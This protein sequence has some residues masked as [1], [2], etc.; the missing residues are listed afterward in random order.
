MKKDIIRL[1]N[2]FRRENINNLVIA[3]LVIL[4]LISI[5]NVLIPS[6]VSNDR[7]ISRE[8]NITLADG[9]RI[10]D[11][12]GEDITLPY[13]HEPGGSDDPVV[14][15]HDFPD[16]PGG[17]SLVVRA[18]N[19]AVRIYL[20]KDGEYIKFYEKGFLDAGLRAYENES[21]NMSYTVAAE[22]RENVIE[23]PAESAYTIIR[24]ELVPA[25]RHNDMVLESVEMTRYESLIVTR[26]EASFFILICCILIVVC[27][28]ILFISDCVRVFSGWSRWEMPFLIFFGM[29][30]VAY[31]VTRQSLFETLLGNSQFFDFSSTFALANLPVILIAH[32]AKRGSGRE[33]RHF[34][35]ATVFLLAIALVLDFLFATNTE[36]RSTVKAIAV[37]TMLL[38]LVMAVAALIVTGIRTSNKL[39]YVDAGAYC[40]LFVGFA[41]NT[42]DIFSQ[43]GSSNHDNQ[44]M[45]CILTFFAIITITSVI[46]LISE[47]RR[48]SEKAEREAIAANEAKS[49]F[50]SSM[51]HEIRTPI[52]AVLGMNEMILRES[53]EDAIIGYSESIRTA[54]NTLLGLINDILD[55]SKIESGKMDILPAA[56]DLASVLNDLVN[57][58]HTKAEAKGLEL[59]MNIDKDTPKALFGDEIRVK[60]VI[61]NILSN[62]VK[63]TEKGSIT[64]A[65]GYDRI[66]GDDSAVMLNVSIS[67]TGIGIKKEDMAKLFSAFERIEELRNRSVEGT[68]LGMS[69]TQR[70][71]A[72]MDSSLKVES[73]YGKGSTF[74]FSLRQGVIKWEPVGDYE[75]AFRRSL[76]ERRIYRERFTAPDADILVIDDT[77]MNLSVFVNLL[78]RT[79]IRIDT[80]ASGDDG[81][82]LASK[83]K[84]DIIFIDHMMPDKDGIETLEQM[85]RDGLN[86]GTPAVCLTANAVA[87]AREKYLSAGFDDYLTKPIESSKLEKMI[88]AYLPD[89]KVH[90]SS[91]DDTSA[92]LEDDDITLP[93]WLND[94]PEIDVS[95][96]LAHCETAAAYIDALKIYADAVSGNVS[97]IER[98]MEAGDLKN[99][100]VKI[101][102]LKS[103]SR[104]IGAKDLGSLAEELENAGNAQDASAV[105]DRLPILL[106]RCRALGTALAPLTQTA[107]D[108]S[109]LTPVDEVT[110]AEMYTA[111]KEFMSVSDYDSAVDIIA[112][113]KDLRVPDGEKERRQRLIRAADEVRYEDIAGIL[114]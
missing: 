68:G 19:S 60:Q 82:L 18:H 77:P 73:E 80:A 8:Q 109:K 54:G 37:C 69:I 51:S 35:N 32:F 46:S 105:S 97:E 26:L 49:E 41:L 78:K 106:E 15:E 55:F 14:L 112:G 3:A 6:F 48:R 56:Y 88:M 59:R 50:L 53:T 10:A 34:K 96:G 61:T 9:W 12:T 99:A 22:S 110:L 39:K 81:I 85:K 94:I 87:G 66:E 104:I 71:L 25:S 30:C 33:R 98:F 13:I 4:M 86:A 42:A 72:L 29:T 7:M 5:F 76:A 23:L 108:D 16:N 67:D 44:Q 113:L 91:G 17:L 63:Y 79:Q 24:I 27:C 1:R 62:A 114:S 90:P 89:D 28:V 64:L 43:D 45:M 2:I 93:G 65:L 95:D 21:G 11:G 74:S 52:N 75:E 84:Y 83:N 36:L 70:L 111:I 20:G 58:V 100:T 47:Y 40:V 107:E 103:T 38:I 101:H 57:M 31:M 102:A 92:G